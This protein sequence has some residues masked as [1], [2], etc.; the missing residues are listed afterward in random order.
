MTTT[1]S[2]INDFELVYR[3]I[4]EVYKTKKNHVE[5]WSEIASL[6]NNKNTIFVK[7]Y[8]ALLNDPLFSEISLNYAA[9]SKQLEDGI[10]TEKNPLIKASLIIVHT[11]QIIYDLMTQEGNYYFTLNG[12]DEM[13]V[14]KDMNK[15]IVYYINLIDVNEK[16]PGFHA[17]FLQY[18]LESVFDKRFYLGIDF[19]YTERK[20]K[21]A[22][23]NFEHSIDNRSI[24]ILIP[25]PNIEEEIMDNFINLIMCN[26]R[27]K[28]I[29]HGADALDVPYVFDQMLKGEPELIIPFTKSFIDTRFLCENYKLNKIG[30]SEYKCSIYDLDPD[31][32]AIY[33]FGVVNKEQQDRLSELLDSMPH[34]NEIDWRLHKMSKSQI[35]YA[36]YDVIF[37]KYFY[38]R[39]INLATDEE[40]DDLAKKGIIELYKCVLY[41]LTQFA[42]LESKAI[43]FLLSKC[44]EEVDPANNFM[45]RKGGSTWKMIDV[46]NEISIGL[47]VYDPKVE[48]DK[49]IKVNYYK[50]P[51]LTILKKLIYTIIS[52]RCRVFKKK[53][54]I[55]TDKLDN[56][57]VFDFF[58]EI[59]FNHLLKIF[60]SIESTLET[61]IKNYC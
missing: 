7:T 28:K 35:L 53:D 47:V 38:Y 41:E 19:E 55:W 18:A 44:K 56:Q 32:S 20:I 43:T 24:I 5:K 42:V 2:I 23:L 51:I 45:V 25:P 26:E 52:R 57:Y 30:S 10:G 16:N 27:I 58:K 3:E 17:Y 13:Q 21:L 61:K 37:L 9:N 14:L 40:S 8:H 33:F 31:N 59:G 39:I 34:P 22:Q 36:Q 15:D 54:E 49:V 48:I 1:T 60:K 6:F 4:L 46:Y 12:A 50:K 11:H 29:L